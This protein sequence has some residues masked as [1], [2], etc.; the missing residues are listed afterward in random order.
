MNPK[1]DET[2]W[3][4][5][6]IS[7][8]ANN[9][10]NIGNYESADRSV[11]L[12]KKM[13]LAADISLADEHAIFEQETRRLQALCET[14]NARI[15][16]MF[17]N[18]LDQKAHSD[19]VGIF[20]KVHRMFLLRTKVAFGIEVIEQVANAEALPKAGGIPGV[21]YHIVDINKQLKWVNKAWAE[22]TSAPPAAN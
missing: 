18:D 20:S 2:G 15:V 17:C 11:F 5:V 6:T 14:E 8:S 3:N 13:R 4:E 22:I 10:I 21:I 19:K 9:K 1:I 16:A 7:V 12:T